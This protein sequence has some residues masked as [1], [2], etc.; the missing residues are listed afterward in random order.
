MY[1]FSADL[2][3]ITTFP[4]I[5]YMIEGIDFTSRCVIQVDKNRKNYA[6][7]HSQLFFYEGTCGN[8]VSKPTLLQSD[9][10]SVEIIIINE[11]YD[12]NGD[13]WG[14]PFSTR[15]MPTVVAINV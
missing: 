1:E 4:A 13:M 8:I 12:D 9:G 5:Q 7:I 10:S 2:F 15:Q 14:S 6:K 3:H 11:Q